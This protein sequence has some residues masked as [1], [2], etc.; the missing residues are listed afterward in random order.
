MWTP[1]MLVKIRNV[2]VIVLPS[3]EKKHILLKGVLEVIV[4]IGCVKKSWKIKKGFAMAYSQRQGSAH[5]GA[6]VCVF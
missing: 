6:S 1:E 2:R 3:D 5:V 4:L